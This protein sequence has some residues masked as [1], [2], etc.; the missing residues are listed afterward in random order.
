MG[1][2]ISGST[3]RS[4][5]TLALRAWAWST[6]LWMATPCRST[7]SPRSEGR[8][9]IREI[10]FCRFRDRSALLLQAE[11]RWRVNECMTGAFFYDEG[12]VAS[13]RL[14]DIGPL[15]RDYGVGLRHGS[16]TTGGG[17]EEDRRRI[18]RPR[19]HTLPHEGQ[20]LLYGC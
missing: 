8:R 13:P 19:R 2:S 17:K 14:G 12:A 10:P 7:C 18:R 16:R 4:C 20:G 11:Y 5:I 9:S 1:T 3:S 6:T 15:E